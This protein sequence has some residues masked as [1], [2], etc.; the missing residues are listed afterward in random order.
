[1]AS[2]LINIDVDDLQKGI[3]FYTGGFDLRVG[4]RFGRLAVELLGFEAPIYLLV[5]ASGT[6]AFAGD[7]R[8]RDYR[9]HWTPVHLDVTVADLEAA[10]ARAVAA[11]A[12]Q[13]GEIESHAWGRIAFVSDPF[14]HGLCLLQ[15]SAAGYDA[16]AT[17]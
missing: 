11:G 15:L 16:I 9:R 2:L 7:E 10:I 13:E 8:R 4:R 1:M 12:T 17:P 6:V 5:K 3:D 14:G